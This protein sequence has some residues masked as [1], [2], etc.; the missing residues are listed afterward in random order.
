MTTE[1]QPTCKRTAHPQVSRYFLR[2]NRGWDWAV[3]FVDRSGTLAI[4]SSY[5]EYGHHWSNFGPD[6]FREFLCGLHKDY[7][8]GKLCQGRP[9]E[10]D[11]AAS[12]K[13]IREEIRESRRRGQLTRE[14]ARIEWELSEALGAGSTVDD[15]KDWYD[16]TE[17]RPGDAYELLRYRYP[18]A[19]DFFERVWTPFVACLRAEMIA[20]AAV[21]DAASPPLTTGAGDGGG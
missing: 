6:D 18:I 2:C 20:E 4:V 7:L 3:F 1:E 10:L 19:H 13:A 9:K 16:E 5:G 14:R 8:Y 17:L 15:A 21:L 12:L 11:G